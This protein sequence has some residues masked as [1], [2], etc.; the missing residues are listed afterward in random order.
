MSAL[1]ARLK[2]S[3]PK[4]Q[5]T[6]FPSKTAMTSMWNYAATFFVL[7]V[8]TSIAQMS[9]S[10]YLTTTHSTKYLCGNMRQPSSSYLLVT[11]GTA[12]MPLSIFLTTTH[13][14]KYWG[15]TMRQPSCSY[16]FGHKHFLQH[17]CDRCLAAS[18]NSEHCRSRHEFVWASSVEEV[19]VPCVEEYQ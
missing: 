1:T 9:L 15:G 6:K 2:A 8:Y 16:F 18:C 19:C 12:Q 11:T 13:S 5:S 10:I 14:T 3:L 17:R 4:M 7:L